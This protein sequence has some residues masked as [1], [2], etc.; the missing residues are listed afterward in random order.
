MA[1]VHIE[2]GISLFEFSAIYVMNA[3]KTNF[4][5]CSKDKKMFGGYFLVAVNFRFKVRLL[6][7]TLMKFVSQV[8]LRLLVWAELWKLFYDCKFSLL[9]RYFALSA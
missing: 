8:V 1:L 7:R 2:V 3:I 5:Y 4:N 9:L 6:G